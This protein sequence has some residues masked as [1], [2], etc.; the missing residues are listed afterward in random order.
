MASDPVFLA[1]AVEAVVRAGDIMMDRFGGDLR[2]DKKGRIA[3]TWRKVKVPGHAAEVL[4][5]AKEL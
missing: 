4:A 1:T 2:V 5:A 3:R